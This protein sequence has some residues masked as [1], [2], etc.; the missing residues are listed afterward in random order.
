MSAALNAATLDEVD[1]DSNDSNQGERRGSKMLDNALDMKPGKWAWKM[2]GDDKWVLA[3]AFGGS[4]VAGLMFPALA[5]V[6][7]Q[8]INE[9]IG[10]NRPTQIR[11]WALGFVG[12]SIVNLLVR[13]DT[14]MQSHL[15]P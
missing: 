10:L 6:L 3:L 7:S 1:V 14:A 2:A 13:S 11:N 12:L 5:V 4:I 8:A 15:A 9:A